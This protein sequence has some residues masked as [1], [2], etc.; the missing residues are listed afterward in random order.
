MDNQRLFLFIALSLVILLLWQAWQE[1][2]GT[3]PKPVS[4]PSAGTTKPSEGPSAELPSVVEPESGDKPV[5]VEPESGDKPVVVE[6][7]RPTPAQPTATPKDV[8]KSGQRIHVTTDLLS[9]DIDTVGGDLREA[10]L[11]AYSVAADKPNVPYRLLFDNPPN[12]YVAQ[13]GL[14]GKGDSAAPDH[15]AVFTADQ[16]DYRLA[17]GAD[18]LKVTLKWKNPQGVSIAK[19]Y[20]FHRNSYIIDV[21]FQVDNRSTNEWQGRLYTQLQRTKVAKQ[22]RFIYTYTG[23]V[24]SSKIN[25]YEKIKFDNMAEWKPK[26]S[27]YQGGWAAMLQHYFIAG[28]IPNQEAYVHYYTNVVGGTRYIIGYTTQEKAIAAGQTGNLSTKLYVGPKK[29]HRMAKA[30]PNLELTVDYGILTVLAQP[31]YWLLEHIHTLLGNWGWSIVVLTILIKLVFYKLSET[32]YRSMAK[33]RRFQPKI[34][35]IRERFGDDKQRMSQAMMELYR[36][37]K[38]NPLGGCLPIVVQI[39]VFIALYWMLLESVELRQADFIFW[40]KDLAT[41]DPF[42][43]LPVLMGISM[44][45]QQRLNPAPMDPVQQKVLSILPVVFTLFFAFFPAGLVLYWL[46][47]NLLSIAQQWYITRKIEAGTKD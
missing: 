18:Q 46:T 2:Y 3:T 20:T 17:P 32:S 8:L 4:P 16:T 28:L 13:S 21:D 12:L 5:V 35:S 36:K 27:Y 26:E 39:P 41:K 38:I 24:V 42:Y 15:H 9:V 37:E 40:I 23:G 25:K 11:L 34:A 7:Q 33:M 1:Q 19:I 43:V 30:A 29:Q 47:N 31:L 6:P 14:I 22:S 45:F 10:D 44:F